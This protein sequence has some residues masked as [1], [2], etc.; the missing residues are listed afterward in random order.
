MS[1]TEVIPDIRLPEVLKTGKAKYD[2]DQL[3][4]NNRVLTNMIPVVLK[5]RVR[6]AVASFRHMTDVQKLAE[7]LTGVQKYVDALRAQSHE[8][9]NRIHTIAGLLQLG[10]FQEAVELIMEVNLKDQGMA[11]VLVRK[12]KSPLI[13]GLL[14]GK[15]A[16]AKE[17]GVELVIDGDSSLE[18]ISTKFFEIQLITV[19]GNLID[20]ACD[21]VAN[22]EKN[23][24]KARILLNDQG[25][26]LV[27]AVEDW[28]TG[29]SDNAAPK[30]YEQ[31]F[32]TKSEKNK[33]IGLTLCKN[34]VAEQSGGISWH[35]KPEGGVVFQIM[36]PKGKVRDDESGTG[37][38]YRG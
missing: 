29:I 9:K 22:M 17:N 20:N 4:C 12:I 5:G 36:I 28:G 1:I 7:K 3:F 13:G 30:I 2:Q 26:S 31:G 8:F 14:L 19:I 37:V 24:R 15:L 23:R 34:F 21:A 33:G 35:N 10:E 38:D 11:D 25:E 16:V 18:P 6:G 32:T 27:I